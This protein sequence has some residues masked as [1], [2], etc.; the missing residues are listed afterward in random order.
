M[1]VVFIGD[2]ITQ[3]WSNPAPHGG[4]QLPYLPSVNKGIG[5]NTTEDMEARFTADVLDQ[6]PALVVIDGGT[7]D[8]VLGL[9]LAQS[10]AAL[11]N[12]IETAKM[13]GIKVVIATQLPSTDRARPTALLLQWNAMIKSLALSE[14]IPLADYFSVIAGPENLPLAGMLY[15][16]VHPDIKGFTAMDPVAASA[17]NNGLR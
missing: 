16:G 7:N 15:D 3:I 13:H 2:S 14:A 4:N 10:T 17:I 11:T 9:T 1:L 6:H 8:I 12:M 5:G